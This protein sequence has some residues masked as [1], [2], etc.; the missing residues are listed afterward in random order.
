MGVPEIGVGMLGQG[1]MG[2]AH[3][4]AFRRLGDVISPPPLLPRLVAVAGRNEEALGQTATRY[5]YER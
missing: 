2:R 4:G 1:F 3:S 5:G